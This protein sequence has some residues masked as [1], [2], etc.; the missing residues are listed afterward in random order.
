MLERGKGSIREER[1]YSK[2]DKRK[3][4]K[5]SCCKYYNHNQTSNMLVTRQIADREKE[6]EGIKHCSAE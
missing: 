5:G 1:L 4:K 3:K 2:T 6:R